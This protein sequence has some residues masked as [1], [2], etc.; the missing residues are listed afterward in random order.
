MTIPI[1]PA[2]T[3]ILMREEIKGDFEIFMVKRSSRSTF[4][5]LYVFPGGKL[6]PEDSEN[7][8]YPYCEGMNN[9]EASKQL[10]IKD[11]GLSF[12]IA[13]IRECFEE[14]GVLLTN[15]DDSILQDTYKLT[16]LRKELN[17]KEITFKEICVS[18]SLRLRT[19]NIVPCAH[20]ITPDIETK[21]FDTRF[22]LAKVNAK[23]LASHD[24]FELTESFWIKPA[25][26]LAK[27]KNGE[28][29]MILPT[30]KNIEKLAEF[31]SSTEA[32]N[33]FEGLGD[34]AIPPILPKFIKKDGEWVGFL[35]GE[36][37]YENV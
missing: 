30:I 25:D 27:L 19:K 21:R 2:A 15:P 7:D 31:S 5:S 24:G 35:P 18:E 26:A 34:N 12:W 22:F 1:K 13:C 33:Y 9:E 14:V 16:K 32:F 23:Q 17:N 20:W 4:G 8:L 29:N 6:D 37:G 28:M 36:E 3:V 10:G 11:N